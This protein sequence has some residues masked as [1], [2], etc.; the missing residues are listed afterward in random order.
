MSFYYKTIPLSFGGKQEEKTG[1]PAA[2]DIFLC[3]N[4]KHT[5]IYTHGGPWEDRKRDRKR[6]MFLQPTAFFKEI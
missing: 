6:I 3:C 5:H 1:H 4:M 2:G